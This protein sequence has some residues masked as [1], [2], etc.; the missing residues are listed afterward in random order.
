MFATDHYSAKSSPQ[1]E[2]DLIRKNV[3]DDHGVIQQ[4]VKKFNQGAMAQ[5][6]EEHTSYKVLIVEDNEDMQWFLY[7][8]LSEGHTVYQAFNGEQGIELAV[9]KQPDIILSDVMMPL[10]DGYAMTKILKQQAETAHIP[11]IFLTAKGNVEHEMEGLEAGG[12]DYIPKPF[13]LEILK[14]KINN[15]LASTRSLIK[16]VGNVGGY[17]PSNIK[18]DAID[19]GF[20]QKITK[21]VESNLANPEL[22]GDTLAL[23]VGMSKSNLYKRLKQMTNLSVNI[24]IRNIRLNI[25]A[26]ILAKGDCCVSDVAYSVGFN[27]PKYFSTCFNQYFELSPKEYMQRYELK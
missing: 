20:I 27:N 11:V 4:N 25:A 2:E 1:Q 9:E 3:L 13:N 26:R 16:R 22:S 14:K 12:D 23:E 24:F 10:M 5:E 17:I 18:V 19:E 8:E 21:Y 7:Q 6:V 15:R